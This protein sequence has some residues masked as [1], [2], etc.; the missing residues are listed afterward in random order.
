MALVRIRE[1]K[2]GYGN[3]H[4][5]MEQLKEV[6]IDP[7]TY[8]LVLFNL[9]C[10]V[11]NG[12]L[13]N[14]GSILI[15]SMG[16]SKLDAY[17]M[18]LPQFAVEVV[19]I[20]VFG[21]AAQLLKKR[22]NIAVFANCINLLGGC[23][24]AFGVNNHMKY[25]GLCLFGMSSIPWICLMSLVTSNTL[26]HTKKVVTA[27]LALI[28][29]CVGNLIGPQTFLVREAPTYQTAKIL[30]VVC[31]LVSLLLLLGLYALNVWENKRRDRK[32]EKLPPEFVNS[33][34]ADLTDFQNPEFR[35]A[36]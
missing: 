31:Y 9:F 22:M 26:G 11:P 8:I 1:N 14:F 18:N 4:F 36:L 2:Q 20:F 33:E 21:F 12:S 13:T 17:I 5:K 35:Y 23:F 34:F 15:E 7:R 29:Y 10:E 30:I 32:N 6:F 25:A 28:A 16:Y 24:L 3:R 19:G 27:A